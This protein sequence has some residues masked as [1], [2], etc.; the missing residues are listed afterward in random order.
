MRT[1]T[2]YD[3]R[4]HWIR[5]SVSQAARCR[6]M[7]S[8]VLTEPT[9]SLDSRAATSSRTIKGRS[10]APRYLVH[11]VPAI[12]RAPRYLAHIVPGHHSFLVSKSP[13]IGGS[14]LSQLLSVILSPTHA[15][16]SSGT[17]RRPVVMLSSISSIP[18]PVEQSPP[19][20]QRASKK[21][22]DEGLELKS[23]NTHMLY[24]FGSMTLMGAFEAQALSQVH[25]ST[26]MVTAAAALAAAYVLA[27]LGTG[28]YHWSVDNYGSG[29]TP[30][31]GAQIAA[32]QGHHQKPW[33]ITQR[34]F[35]NNVHLVFKPAA[36]PT[37][38]FLA[39]AGAAPLAF[40]AF[41][42]PFIFLVCMSQQTHAW[43]HMKKSE[44]P[45]PVLA[46]QE[47]GILLS[48]KSHGAHHMAPFE[49]NY[50]IVSGMWN[51][52]LDSTLFFRQ[53]ETVVHSIT[54]VEPRCWSEPD[55]GWEALEE[56]SA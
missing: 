6:A 46:L 47:A 49:G 11:I 32:F 15:S 54:G 35:C 2:C 3:Q 12:T 52:L 17:A 9:S 16:P 38:L 45:A 5:S 26:D 14:I 19:P 55:Y 53:L 20:K 50:C 13:S 51:E 23:N 22:I 36:V 21:V 44:L 48:R 34:E 56:P 1:R 25:D 7:R 28:I 39:T 10:R 31:V 37:A 8:C 24:T 29:K 30:L 43:S 42:A 4:G 33:T 18:S 40:N 41:M 27:D